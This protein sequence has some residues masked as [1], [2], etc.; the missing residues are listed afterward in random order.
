MSVI[1]AATAPIIYTFFL[2]ATSAQLGLF[3][4]MKFPSIQVL[5]NA[6]QHASGSPWIMYREVIKHTTLLSSKCAWSF[7]S[8]VLSGDVVSRVAQDWMCVCV[9]NFFN[10]YCPHR[11]FP[12]KFPCA[13]KRSQGQIVDYKR[14]GR[15][16]LRRAY[17]LSQEV[18]D[19]WRQSSLPDSTPDTIVHVL[20][21]YWLIV[22][23]WTHTDWCLWLLFQLLFKSAMF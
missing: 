22:G 15:G 16:S 1:P 9:C 5:Y 20:N 13:S 14:R 2:F 17:C 23:L 21:V 19:T 18:R 3:G 10:V 4:K 7:S 8:Q 6:N 12:Q 11:Y